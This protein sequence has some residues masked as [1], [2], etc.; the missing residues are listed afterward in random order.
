MDNMYEKLELFLKKYPKKENEK[1]THSII[2]PKEEMGSWTI[3]I[4]NLDDFY[5]YVYYNKNIIHNFT[6]IKNT[7]L[8]TIY[9]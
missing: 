1:T 6:I 3:P 2:H 7:Y 9:V 4:E 5:N 8:T